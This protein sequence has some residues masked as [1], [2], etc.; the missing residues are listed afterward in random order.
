MIWGM[1]EGGFAI[2]IVVALLILSCLVYI[3]GRGLMYF[4]YV[5]V[6]VATAA[7]RRSLQEKNKSADDEQGG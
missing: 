5:V 2:W 6:R 3:G 7:A 1:S 4:V